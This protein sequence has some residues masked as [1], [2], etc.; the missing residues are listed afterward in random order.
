VKLRQ[1]VSLE[2][3]GEPGAGPGTRPGT[4]SANYNV[5]EVTARRSWTR[6][7]SAGRKKVSKDI[8]AFERASNS[9]KTTA[10]APSAW[11]F[12]CNKNTHLVIGRFLSYL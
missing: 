2:V 6:V 7:G 5:L 12:D 8:T 11:R 3:D 4:C 9:A 10:P 1:P